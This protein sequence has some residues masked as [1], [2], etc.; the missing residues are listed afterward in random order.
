MIK[1]IRTDSK[2]SDFHELITILDND[3]NSRY[4]EIQNQYNPFNKIEF[5]DTV[6]I[7]Y[8]G[9]KPVGCGCFKNFDVDTV[10]IKRMIVKP[11]FR[12]GGV[13]QQILSE[14][15]EWAVEK[16]YSKSIL[17]TGA[18]QPEAIRFYLKSGYQKIDNYGQYIG[19]LNSIC[20][21][22]SLTL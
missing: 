5:L 22:K 19:N 10:E 16:G 13:A 9:N 1:T 21:S 17:E 3:L 11:E 12:G 20:M 7:A 2:N 15:E 8:S 4:G 6:V 14:L 18:K